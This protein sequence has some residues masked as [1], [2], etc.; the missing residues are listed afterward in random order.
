MIEVHAIPRLV[1]FKNLF[2]FFVSDEPKL[3]NHRY[4]KKDDPLRAVVSLPDVIKKKNLS[5]I[6]C[7]VYLIINN[8]KHQ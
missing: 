4:Q 8:T 2:G 7:T 1:L 3:R 6:S 5:C